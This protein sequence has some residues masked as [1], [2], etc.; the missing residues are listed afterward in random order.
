MYGTVNRALQRFLRD[1]YGDAAWAEIARDA[2]LRIEEF[3]PLVPYPPELTERLLTVAAGRLRQDPGDLLEDLGTHLVAA[4]TCE[5]PRRL[6]RF[7]GETLGEFLHS[8]DEIP[9]R[10]RLVLPEFDIPRIEVAFEPPGRF[11]IG[12]APGLPGFSL[13]LAGVL[14]GLT[15]DYGA[16]AVIDHV[17]GRGGEARITVDVRDSDF[18]QGRSFDLAARVAS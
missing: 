7:G 14:R 6:L 2:G 18:A 16:L 10:I 13:V 9:E 1:T 8:V 4:R 15:D 3:E 17:G 5:A 12:V 11:V